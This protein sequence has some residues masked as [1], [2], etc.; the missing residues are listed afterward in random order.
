MTQAA[1]LIGVDIE[2]E[3][4]ARYG[5]TISFNSLRNSHISFLVNSWL[6]TL[7]DINSV[8]PEM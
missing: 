7:L 2:I 4:T 8:K 6:V 1:E 3:L 5:H